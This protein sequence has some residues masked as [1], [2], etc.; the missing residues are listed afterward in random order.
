MYLHGH[1]AGRGLHV[2]EGDDMVIQHLW[3]CRSRAL[4]GRFNGC[5]LATRKDSPQGQPASTL[6]EPA[7]RSLLECTVAAWD[8]DGQ[9]GHAVQFV[10]QVQHVNTLSGTSTRLEECCTI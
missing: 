5:G 2:I 7:V 10:E 9:D 3:Q 8:G 1:Q 4:W 6:T